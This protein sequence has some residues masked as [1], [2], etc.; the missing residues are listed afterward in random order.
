MKFL[1]KARFS[2]K[3][4]RYEKGSIFETD[5]P[6]A[7]QKGKE[8]GVISEGAKPEFVPATKVQPKPPVAGSLTLDQALAAL[9]HADD[10]HWTKAGLPDLTVLKELTGKVVTRKELNAAHPDFVR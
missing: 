3:G 1:V 4:T 7:I 10:L 2:H 9:D 8:A 6:A 5:D